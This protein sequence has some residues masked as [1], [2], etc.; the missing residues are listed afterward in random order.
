MAR[1]GGAVGAIHPSTY[2]PFDYAQGPRAKS[3]GQDGERYS[4]RE[5][6]LRKDSLLLREGGLRPPLNLATAPRPLH[7]GNCAPVEIPFA[8]IG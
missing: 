5:S 8:N 1:K 6:P 4:N 3:R 2:A 7:A